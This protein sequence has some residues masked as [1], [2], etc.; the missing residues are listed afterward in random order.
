[1]MRME[2]A[3]TKIAIKGPERNIYRQIHGIHENVPVFKWTEFE[4]D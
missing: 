2:I 4:V 1:M 3:A